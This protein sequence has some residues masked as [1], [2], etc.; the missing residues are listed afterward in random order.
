MVLAPRCRD[1]ESWGLKDAVPFLD[2]GRDRKRFLEAAKQ[3]KRSMLTLLLSLLTGSKTPCDAM[4][5]ENSVAP[6]LR[7]LPFAEKMDGADRTW[8]V[9]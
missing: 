4:R 3:E 6:K 2:G 7:A 5:H 9:R 8:S 1:E